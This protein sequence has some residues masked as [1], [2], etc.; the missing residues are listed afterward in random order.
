MLASPI[1]LDFIAGSRWLAVGLDNGTVM[2]RLSTMYDLR[3]FAGMMQ[4][5]H[6]FLLANILIG[7]PRRVKPV[8]LHMCLPFYFSFT[9][10]FD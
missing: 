8:S 9:K 6:I 1:C 10:Q 2:V 7:I 5:K 3:W 4:K